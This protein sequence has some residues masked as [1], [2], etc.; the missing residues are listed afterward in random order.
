MT[1]M[2]TALKNL[3]RDISHKGFFH[4]FSANLIISFLAFGSQLLVVKFLT[5]TEIANIK[6][7]QSFV[8]VVG[9]LAGFGFNTSVLKLC[10][11]KRTPEEKH[12]VLNR[13][14]NYS[15]VSLSITMAGMFIIA[16]LNLFSPAKEVNDWMKVYMFVIPASVCTSIFMTYLQALKKIKL[17]ANMQV[18]LRIAGVVILVIATFYLRFMGYIF[19]T[20][21]IGALGLYPLW[22]L[23]RADFL[24]GRKQTRRVEKIVYY[25]KWSFA[26]LLVNQISIYID[27]F[28]LNYLITDR[29]KMGYYSIAT[30]FFMGLTQIT[31]T[32]QSIA[33][34][35][36]SEKSNDKTEFVR[37]LKKY[38]KIMVL[39]SLGVT[40]AS[41]IILPSF[42]RMIYGASYA[43]AG[44]YT[45]LIT[46]RYFLV[47]CYALLGVA[48]LGLGMMKF[49]F[50]TSVITCVIN[51]PVNYFFIRW[52]GV[53]G[54]AYA[55]VFSCA[56]IL[57][58]MIV[59]T[60]HVLKMHFSGNAAA[61]EFAVSQNSV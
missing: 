5:L 1:T 2:L 15:L 8:A 52:M 25:A 53:S 29:D 7:L 48:I 3:I 20:V 6:T 30:I 27:I 10:S 40:I 31:A 45:V 23:V 17:M 13:A 55:Q 47:S 33:T 44:D 28:L 36:F 54:A 21:L 22:R 46:I 43:V 26:A 41:I 61:A 35:Y 57:V 56:C 37:A 42:I 4:L 9:V 59:M 60:R 18:L 32:V 24:N 38:Q 19:S 49:N 50:Y 34:P 12:Y 11:E 58:M 16:Q 51:I 39:G 14:F